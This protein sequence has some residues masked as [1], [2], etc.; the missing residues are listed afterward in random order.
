MSIPLSVRIEILGSDWTD[1]RENSYLEVFRK[2]AEKI[3]L[4]L[5]SAQ[6]NGYFTRRFLYTCDL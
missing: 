4:P 5:K 6:N 2:S 1:F 3:Q